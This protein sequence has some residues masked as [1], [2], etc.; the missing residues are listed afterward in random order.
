MNI[1]L[2]EVYSNPHDDFEE[3]KSSVEEVASLLEA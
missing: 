3:F 1:N 2:E